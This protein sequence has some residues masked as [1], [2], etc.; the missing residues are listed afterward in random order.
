MLALSCDPPRDIAE[1]GNLVKCHCSSDNSC[2][3]D[4]FKV[5][6]TPPTHNETEDGQLC[7]L[8]SAHGNVNTDP[9]TTCLMK[10]E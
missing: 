5:A 1:G 10:V 4:S 6:N 2:L 3:S 7:G 8:W 9:G